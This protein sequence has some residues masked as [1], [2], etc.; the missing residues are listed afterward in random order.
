MRLVRRRTVDLDGTTLSVLDGGDGPPVLLHPSLG[1]GADDFADL[2]AA[3]VHAGHR[4]VAIDPRG[5]GASAPAPEGLTL[6]RIADDLV[7]VADALGI[8]RFAAVGHAFG[9]RVVRMAAARHPGRSTAI[10]LLGAGGKVPG[11]PEARAAVGRCFD[12]TLTRDERLAAI[13]TAFFA[14][15]ND[16]AVWLDGWYPEGKAVQQQAL[17]GATTGDW[18]HADDAPMLVVQGLQDRAAPPENGRLLARDRTAPTTLVEVDGAGHALLP[19]Q[20]DAVRAAVLPFLAT[21]TG[22][23]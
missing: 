4:A 2:L 5:I 20:P 7:A 19:E 1:R 23:S 10:V 11:D 14:P 21:H 3:L 9:N 22:R 6:E 13:A 15:G 12:T 18:W 17:L 16:P 8:G